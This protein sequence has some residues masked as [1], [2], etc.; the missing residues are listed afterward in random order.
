MKM[1]PTNSRPELKTRHLEFTCKA[2]ILEV[3]HGTKQLDVWIPYPTTDENQEVHDIKV[4][5]PVTGTVYTEPKYHNAI[6]YFPIRDSHAQEIDIELSFKV[7]RSENLRKDFP[8]LKQ[9]AVRTIDPHL[10]MYLGPDK[11]VPIDDQVISWARD[12]IKD[13]ET[14]LEKAKAIYD[15]TATTLTYDRSG[16][17]WGRGDLL[18]ACDVK[19]GNCT[20][21]HSVFIGLCRAVEIPARFIIGVPLPAKRG[22]GE[23]RGYHCWAE[24]Y[25]TGYGWIPVDV[26]EASKR[27]EKQDYFFGANDE[28]RVQFSIGRDIVLRPRQ[29]S[30]PLNYFIYPHAE[31]DGKP[32]EAI[33]CVFRYRDIE[34]NTPAL[35]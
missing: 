4:A 14:D 25:L 17:G 28:N 20:D 24:F 5:A 13:K 10:G 27:P 6:M 26:S 22:E 1:S 16:E 35:T 8:D 15:H 29:Q 11:L 31:A 18:Y 2:T 34:D 21:F 30:D 9:A 23:I 12:V 3:P 19:R 32:V 33:R 7:T